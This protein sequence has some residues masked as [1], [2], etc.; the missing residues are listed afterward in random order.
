MLPG[1]YGI[2]SREAL[3]KSYVKKAAWSSGPE[4]MAARLNQGPPTPDTDSRHT[5]TA[6]SESS[7]MRLEMADIFRKV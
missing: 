4:G 3:S 6:A 2:A 7:P 5:H 1:L